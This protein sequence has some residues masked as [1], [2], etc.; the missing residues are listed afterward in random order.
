[1]G[2][3]S[4]LKS[5]LGLDQ[6]PL[7]V[8]DSGP[9]ELSD[10]AR[11]RLAELPEGH[12]IHISSRKVDRGRTVLVDEGPA[13]GPSPEGYAGLTIGDR[14]LERMRGLQL[15]YQN[16][17]WH[18]ATHLELRARE[19]PNPDGR[20]YLCNRHLTDGGARFFDTN[21]PL[22]PDLAAML[23]DV[24]QVRTVLL[25]KNTV[26]IEREKD[27]P[28]EPIDQAVSVVLRAY[29]LGMGHRLE[30]EASSHDDELVRK[31]QEVL[32]VSVLP[33]IHADGGDME[34]LGVVDGVAKV[35]LQGACRSCPASTI[36]LQN[37]VA[38]TLREA[39]PGQITD[40]ENIPG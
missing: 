18:V 11:A 36:T 6:K 7:D 37:G 33:G 3:M 5:A 19:T 35:R 12:A 10:A 14:D 8:R 38:R 31:V 17:G 25:R 4:T 23:L 1:M 28:W 9:L 22:T 16:G 34:L 2:L 32:N 21:G 40:V 26:T 15:D 29:F 20:L 30:A 13:Q 27:S 39:F 24:P